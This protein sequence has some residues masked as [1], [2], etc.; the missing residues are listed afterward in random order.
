[1]NPMPEATLRRGSREVRT[2]LLDAARS[3]FAAKGF[4][5]ATT[6][7]IALAAGVSEALLFRHFGTKEELVR[8]A[9]LTPLR[10]LVGTYADGW[11]AD[12]DA[13]APGPPR[14]VRGLY[15]VLHERRHLLLALLASDDHGR[16][17]SA[18]GGRPDPRAR[19]SSG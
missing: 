18:P 12:A 19:R 1:M 4:A 9:V 7:D 6:R 2:L 5:G 13:E 17:P 15:E 8:Q 10:E 14:S 3:L 16:D 11:R